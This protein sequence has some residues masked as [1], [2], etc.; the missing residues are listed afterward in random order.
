VSKYHQWVA[1]VAAWLVAAAGAAAVPGSDDSYVSYSGTALAERTG[2]FLYGEKD[3]LRY[4]DGRMTARVVV[5]TCRDG[6]AFAR[7]TASYEDPLVP[8]FELEDA[9]NGM[10]QGIRT[11]DGARR[12]FFR[13]DRGAAEKTSIVLP[14]SGLVADSGFDAFLRANWQPLI[15]GHTVGLHFLVPSRL[16]EMGFKVQHV[17]S[18]Q[19]DGMP[20]EMF[21][22]KLAGWLGW[23][24]PSID[25][26][27]GAQDHT[28]VRYVGLSDL[29]DADND[30]LYASIDFRPSDRKSATVRDLQDALQAPLAPCR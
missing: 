4:R 9:S 10:R 13:A 19:I 6:S 23:I 25:A 12:V 24:A 22:L 16:E 29:R 1:V 3:V 21:R 11:D 27:Y 14:V 26:Y 5:Y 28:L 30:N 18:A 8:D 17:R 20:V 7:K 2:A 15:E